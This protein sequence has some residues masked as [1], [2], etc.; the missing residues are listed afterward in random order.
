LAG[1]PSVYL[2]LS[3]YPEEATA[4]L[5]RLLDDPLRKNR[6]VALRALAGSPPSA[7][8]QVTTAALD[9]S[10]SSEDGVLGHA[11]TLLGSLYAGA[12]RLDPRVENALRGGLLSNQRF[13]R[14]EAA[15]AVGAIGPAAE[16]LVEDLRRVAADSES[17][18][19]RSNA[20]AALK[21]VLPRDQ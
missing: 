2:V 16:N 4:P 14:Q 15:D 12:E 8:D 18:V 10:T 11:L 9:L 5:L 19:V 20:E 1:G 6:V 21:S 7:R 3:D 17:P 13:V